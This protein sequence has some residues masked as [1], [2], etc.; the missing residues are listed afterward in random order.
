MHSELSDFL[1]FPPDKTACLVLGPA[2]EL[3]LHIAYWQPVAFHEFRAFV[4]HTFCYS[5]VL[6]PY[7]CDTN[8]T[9]LAEWFRPDPADD[10]LAYELLCANSTTNVEVRDWMQVHYPLV[11]IPWLSEGLHGKLLSMLDGDWPEMLAHD[12]H[13][14]YTVFVADLT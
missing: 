1:A 8:R 7:I 5:S 12:N 2:L 9:D 10:K 14:F 13:G 4:S 11:S 6:Q 3:A